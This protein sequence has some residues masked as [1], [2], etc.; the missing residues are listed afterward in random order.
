[1]FLEYAA[2]MQQSNSQSEAYLLGSPVFVGRADTVVHIRNSLAQTGKLVSLP[3]SFDVTLQPVNSVEMGTPVPFTDC[4]GI[5]STF[6]NLVTGEVDGKRLTDVVVKIEDLLHD[7]SSQHPTHLQRYSLLPISL[8]ALDTSTTF[9]F[10][11]WA[12]WKSV[13]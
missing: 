2:A 3:R 12:I 4:P 10:D 13:V 8:T 9:L 7:F 11:T 5:I 6:N 1:M